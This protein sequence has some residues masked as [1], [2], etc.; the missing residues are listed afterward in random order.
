VCCGFLSLIS[1][2]L[3]IRF[4]VEVLVLQSLELSLEVAGLPA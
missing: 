1:F 4:I 2:S 3:A